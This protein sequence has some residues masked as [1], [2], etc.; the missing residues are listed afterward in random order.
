MAIPLSLIWKSRMQWNQ[1]L[2]LG[3]FFSL[4][5]ILIALS[6]ARAVGL[7]YG[8]DMYEMWQM[9]WLAMSGNFGLILA[10]GSAFRA[11][12]MNQRQ[13]KNMSLSKERGTKEWPNRYS[14]GSGGSARKGETFF[15]DSESESTAVSSSK[16]LTPQSSDPESQG[17]DVEWLGLSSSKTSIASR[18]THG[19]D[20]TFDLSTAAGFFHVQKPRPVLIPP[21]M[22]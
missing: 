13:S 5:S 15:C 4:N 1:K 17:K 22:C 3:V 21:R 9:Y 16:H 19:T 11:F 7:K 6:I 20:E 18:D 14:D 10:A 2:G 12:Y 8:G